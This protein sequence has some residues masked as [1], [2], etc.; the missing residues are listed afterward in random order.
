MQYI[1]KISFDTGSPY[2]AIKTEVCFSQANCHN[3]GFISQDSDTFQF[4]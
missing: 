1:E 3:Q 4:F 2:T